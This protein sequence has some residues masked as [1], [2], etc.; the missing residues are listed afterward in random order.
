M[1]EGSAVLLVTLNLD[2]PAVGFRAGADERETKG[3]PAR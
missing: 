2:L 3:V 1:G